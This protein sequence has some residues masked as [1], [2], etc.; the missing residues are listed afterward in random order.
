M[1]NFAPVKKAEDFEKCP[2]GTFQFVISNFYN[3]GNQTKKD[4]SIKHQC[5]VLYE[6]NKKITTGEYAGKRF[7]LSS[8]YNFTMSKNA[9][10]RKDIE[11][12]DAPMTDE[13]AE[14]FDL[15]TLRGM[16]GSA[17]IV[18]NGEYVNIQNISGLMEG[19]SI[20]EPELPPDYLPDWIKKKIDNQI[21]I[22]EEPAKNN[23][24]KQMYDEINSWASDGLVSFP[25]IKA[26]IKVKVGSDMKFEQLNFEQAE[27]VYN[28]IL[29]QVQL[30]QGTIF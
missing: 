12:I 29:G 17:K 27:D 10:L 5:I 14:G 1:A 22:A 6:I 16:N 21:T 24:I 7:V 30:K 20:I 25:D 26:T 8:F 18:H 15:D 13:Q 19:L 23:L 28:R 4:G 2:Q 9:Q 3:I 11:A